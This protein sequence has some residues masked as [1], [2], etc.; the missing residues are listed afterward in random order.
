MIKR[1][2]MKP[3]SKRSTL[4]G[5]G[6]ALALSAS[7]PLLAADDPI[8]ITTWDQRALYQGWSAER[9]MDTAVRGKNGED[10]GEIENIIVNADGQVEKIIV[11]AGGFMDIGDTHLSIPWD[12][13]E[14]APKLEYVTIPVDEDTV[15]NFSLFA[16]RDDIPAGPRAWRVTEL[17]DDYVQLKDVPNYGYVN[18][19][20][21]DN[22]GQLQA[23]VVSPDFGYGAR[24]YYAYPYYG[25]PYGYEPGMDSYQLPYTRD[26]IANLG[27]FDYSALNEQGEFSAM[28]DAAKQ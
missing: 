20:I 8:D 26:D 15:P 7:S 13:V 23:V 11:E 24:G 27:P 17:I 22:D 12:Q 5:A 18:D 25:Y 21:F 10:I 6:C 14:V 19:L 9:M 4:I 1:L 2:M 28:E 16:G 3:M